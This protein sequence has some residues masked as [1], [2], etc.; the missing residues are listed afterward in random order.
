MVT[1]EN[2]ILKL[3]TCDYVNEVTYYTIFDVDRLSGGFCPNRWN[4]TLLWLFSCPVL[5]LFLVST[6]SSNRAADIHALWLKWRGSAKGLSFYGKDDEWHVWGNVPQPPPLQRG[7]NRRFQ[8]KVTNT[9]TCILSKLLHQFQPNFAQ[10]Y[11]PPNALRGWS[12]HSHNKSKMAD[13][14]HHGKIENFRNGS[15]DFDQIW[16]GEAIQPSWAVRPLKIWNF[17]NLRWRRPPSLKKIEISPYLGRSLTN[18]DQIWHGNAF[19]SF[20]AV[21]PLKVGN[22]ENPRWRQSRNRNISAWFDRF[23]QNL[24]QW[25]SFALAL[26]QAEIPVTSEKSN[27]KGK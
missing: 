10:W 24:A 11:R 18:F 7:V 1:P 16:H 14:R 19:R 15:I 9:K 23:W 21:R 13:G 27:L 4:T 20:W 5:S 26:M 12:N 3:G 2:F 17:E 22:F 8:A 6:L 25:R